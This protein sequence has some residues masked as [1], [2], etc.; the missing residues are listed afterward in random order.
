M[1]RV[2]PVNAND[3]A[4]TNDGRGKNTQGEGVLKGRVSKGQGLQRV[5]VLEG[6]GF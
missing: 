6:R 5:W 4:R 1:N 3:P 2:K